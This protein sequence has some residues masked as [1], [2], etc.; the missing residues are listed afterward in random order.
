MEM[1]EISYAEIEERNNTE[2]EDE[3]TSETTNN[4]QKNQ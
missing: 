4:V 3:E 2:N 1:K